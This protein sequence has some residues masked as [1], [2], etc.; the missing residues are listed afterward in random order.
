[1]YFQASV[2]INIE[3]NRVSLVCLKRSLKEL[4]IAAHT[5]Y[6]LG[7]ED[8]EEKT[9]EIRKVVNEFLRE[10]RIPS[11]DIFLG[12]QRDLTILRYI[13][14]PLAVKE[15]LRGTLLYEME[16]YVPLPVNDIYFDCQIIAED[17]EANKLKVL[18][19]VVKKE[20]IDPYLDVE[21]RFGAGISGIEINST[22]LANY[23]SYKPN[24]PNT[25]TYAMV[26]LGKEHLEL[27]LVHK[28]LLNYSRH[29]KMDQT[30][31]GLQC[32]VLEELELLRKTLGPE[33][34]RLEIVLCGSD[35][36]SVIELLKER[37]D[38]GLR[39]LEL[40]GTGIP[41][42][43]LAPA[44]GLAL[45]GIQKVPMDINLLPVGLRK[46]VSKIGY[47]T[48]FVLAGLF[49]LSALA[50]GGSNILHQKRVSDKFD[51]EIKQLGIEVADINRMQA[52]LKELE[53]KI[54]TINTLRQR[55]VPVLNV[56]RDL[57]KEI[58]DGA[59]FDRLAFTDKGGE[60]EGYADSAS[61]LIPILAASPLLKDVAFLSLITKGKD[62]KERF[63]IG[64]KVR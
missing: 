28:R 50:W 27:S 34:G 59:W 32:L 61:A 35:V 12:I 48:M 53:N 45:K 55:H 16:K 6:P 23:F 18:L 5:I 49:I 4:G 7:K 36:D 60:I 56:L 30:G 39:P 19:I 64:F 3:S 22:A 10:H 24:T 41:S 11:A 2:G 58:P 42:D 47:Y 13:E 25:D 31:G 44:Y 15:N 37:E 54:D 51:S 46:K 29:V 57:S 40:S 1:L 21:N 8:P 52:R 63:R 9:A 62:G 33:Q 14:L 20:L 17:K 38:I 43:L 26:C